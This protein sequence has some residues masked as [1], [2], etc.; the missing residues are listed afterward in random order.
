VGPEVDEYR[1]GECH[2]WYNLG[3]AY[4]KLT[5]YH[6][7]IDAFRHAVR[8]KPTDTRAWYNLGVAYGKSGNR[9]SALD[10]V[11]E[12]RGRDPVLADRLFNQ[13]APAPTQ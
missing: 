5:R 12:L 9:T 6:D 7:A 11:L 8:L 13:I 10:A 2:A 4:G 1:T 3:V